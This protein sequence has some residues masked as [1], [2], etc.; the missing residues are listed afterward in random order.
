MTRMDW[1]MNRNKKKMWKFLIRF[2]SLIVIVAAITNYNGVLKDREIAEQKAKA[3]YEKQLEE[4]GLA[5]TEKG[6]YKDGTYTGSARGYGGTVT[7]S[8]TIKDGMIASVDVVSA[9]NEDAAY[10]NATVG[11]I[12]NIL[13]AQSADIDVVSGATFSSNGLLNAVKEALEQAAEK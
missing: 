7:M 4:L 1:T 9:A 11:L 6:N 2:V 3:E 12:D 13:T 8:V 5:T 10:W